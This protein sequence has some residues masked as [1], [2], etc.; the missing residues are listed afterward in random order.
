MKKKIISWIFE[1]LMVIAFISL[2]DYQYKKDM[3]NYFVIRDSF[4]L[5]LLIKIRAHQLYPND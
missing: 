2:I 4:V 3:M 1:L 5:I